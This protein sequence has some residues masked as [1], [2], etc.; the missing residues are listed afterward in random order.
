[1]IYIPR[2]KVL[3]T[4]FICGLGIVYSVPNLLNKSTLEYLPES[5]RPVKLGLD[6]Q[7]GAHL[8]LEVDTQK[9][10]V[11]RLN[12]HL[13]ALRRGLRSKN[14]GYLNLKS[15]G[16]VITFELRDSSREDDL[17]AVLSD[18]ENIFEVAQEGNTFQLEFLPRE[19]KELTQSMV[20]RSIEIVRRRIDE[21][22]TAEPTIQ[23]Q[24]SDRI[25]VQMPGVDDPARVKKLIGK[26]AKLTFHLVHRDNGKHTSHQTLPSGTR[27]LKS[28]DAREGSILIHRRVLLNGERLIDARLAFDRES[29]KPMVDFR[30]DNLGGRKFAQIT[31]K[32]NVQASPTENRLA[33]VLDDTVLSAPVINTVIR[34]R[35]TISGN[36]TSRE[37]NDL[38]L[39]MR[40]GALPA[41]LEI[42]EERTVGPDLG[43]DSIAAGKMATVV[44]II[45]VGLFMIL[46]YSFF[47]M[48]ANIALV[49]NII[50]LFALLSIIQATLTLPGI[51]GIALTIGMA[52]DAN[53]LIY[54]R[55]KEEIRNGKKIVPA[56]DSG[57]NNAIATIIDSN[58]TTLIAAAALFFFGSGPI[59]G[60]GVTLALGIMISMFTA[61]TLT[62]II[63]SYWLQWK[64]P[65]KL[66]I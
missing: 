17:M 9:G 55:I 66:P 48:V 1:M 60:F 20:R 15:D 47:G 36:F 23:Q 37:A 10:L 7:G 34:D 2:W 3:L 18:V 4:I 11:D 28:Q 24:G 49:F 43:A 32:Y 40:S 30:F 16:Q 14:I 8:L 58:L 31:S 54:E 22:G 19:K 51:A 62:R 57:Y 13:D 6:L 52:V 42:I 56:V 35:G 25:L 39:L 44:A 65:K 26:T 45:L 21:F 38:A 53:V 29:Q 59:K 50:L 27:R 5:M 61:I 63:V 64:R 33:I 46:T 41:P 12:D